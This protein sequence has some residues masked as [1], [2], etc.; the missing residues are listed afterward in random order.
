MATPALPEVLL[1]RYRRFVRDL[2]RFY[3]PD[4]RVP[5][6]LD[7]IE[8]GTVDMD[9]VFSMLCGFAETHDGGWEKTPERVDT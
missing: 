4:R 7:A 8:A 2:I 1:E 5:T 3:V 6:L 9:E